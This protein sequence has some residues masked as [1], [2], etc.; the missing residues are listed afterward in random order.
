M[1]DGLAAKAIAAALGMAI[2]TVENHKIRIFEKLGVRSHAHAVTVAMAYGLA[3]RVRRIVTDARTLTTA[4]GQAGA[5]RRGRSSSWS[6][7]AA[8]ARWTAGRVPPGSAPA[9]SSSWRQP[10]C[11][12]P[13]TPS[14]ER[15][16]AAANAS[17]T[18][19]PAPGRRRRAAS[20]LP[21]AAPPQS[22]RRRQP[23]RAAAAAAPPAVEGVAAGQVLS[24]PARRSRRRPARPSTATTCPPSTPPPS[25]SQDGGRGGRPPPG[26]GRRPPSPAPPAP[27]CRRCPGRPRPC[28]PRWSAAGR[29]SPASAQGPV[30]AGRP[31]R[32]RRPSAACCSSPR[33]PSSCA[34]PAATS[35]PTASAL[36][37]RARSRWRS[38]RPPRTCPLPDPPMAPPA[39]LAPYLP[40]PGRL[41][42]QL[43][44]RLPDVGRRP[45]RELF[46]RQGGGEVDG[47]AGPDR[48]GHRPADRRPRAAP[49]PELPQAGGRGGLRR[50]GRLRGRAE[51]PARRSPARSS[52][53]SLAD[54]ALRPAV[55][56]AGRQAARRRRRR[57]P[58]D[59]RRR[60]PAVVLGR[61]PASRRSPARWSPARLPR[62]DRDF[63]ML[64][65]S[66]LTASKANLELTKEVDYRVERR[67]DGPAGGPAAGRGAQRRGGQRDQPV[68]QRLP[69][70][71]R[72]R[73][74]GAARPRRRHTAP[75][76]LPT[77]AT[78]SSPSPSSSCPKESQGRHL[79]LP[80]AGVGR[81]R[82]PVPTD[83]GTAGGHGPRPPAGPRRRRRVEAGTDRGTL[84]FELASTVH[85]WPR[86]RRRVG[87]S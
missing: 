15:D 6:T 43:V 74:V 57:R 37:P 32:A 62:T 56:P 38:T 16:D 69:A 7:L 11:G 39:G 80:P 41:Q 64:V 24:P 65:D 86:R 18:G 52:S 35:V 66:N 20:A 14:S 77:A 82:R 72:A 29:S 78:R 31:D 68:L 8:G 4:G 33:T 25:R 13:G 87:S 10:T 45:P 75:A 58:F 84:S 3:E 44:A 60:H 12:P 5:R 42:R 63:L 51:A 54:V 59:R 22:S 79:R 53:S 70:G 67:A 9:A 83:L 2:K 23:G 47:V 1:T 71:L 55:Q 27:C 34:R 76:R 49:A 28:A 19:P 85:G 30:P 40:S 61:P 50:A 36:L 26:P 17:S 81:R 46:R 21:A 73:R 48:A